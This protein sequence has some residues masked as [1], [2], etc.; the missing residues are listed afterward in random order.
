MNKAA[1]NVSKV[2]LPGIQLGLSLT[3]NVS[4]T[5]V[6]Y[7]VHAVFKWGIL[8]VLAKLGSPEIVGQFGIAYAI[9]IPVLMFTDL[10]LRQIQATDGRNEYLF[11]HFVALR[12]TTSL[13]AILVIS[14]IAISSGFSW[15]IKIVIITV[16]MAKALESLEDIV[17]GFLQKYERMDRMGI[18]IICKGFLELVAMALGVYVTGGLMSGIVG[19]I[20]VRTFIILTYDRRSIHLV[21]DHSHPG[22]PTEFLPSRSNFLVYKPIW[23]KNILPQLAWLSLPVA[24]AATLISLNGTMPRYFIIHYLGEFD[25][26]IFTALS[27]VL[28]GG[29]MVVMALGLSLSPRLAKYY[30]Q[31]RQAE[32]RRLMFKGLLM[33]GLLCFAGVL[34]A[35]LWG[36]GFLTLIYRPEYACQIKVFLWLMIGGTLGF[37]ANFLRSVI[38]AAR[39]LRVQLP[40]YIVTTLVSMA[41]CYYW[42]P[43]Y[44]LIGAAYAVLCSSLLAFILNSLL[45][46]YI[47]WNHYN[48]VTDLTESVAK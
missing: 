43:L 48:K 25:L 19:L 27:Y 1:N 29:S 23:S 21:L 47:L 18:S 8:V 10:N 32:F 39:Y 45:I 26:G 46:S 16:G 12:L 34:G 41:A 11:G 4:W 38:T 17:Y 15:P 3:H 2:S 37:L 14:G 40:I 33:V 13:L 9:G 6:A 36:G 30:A 28:V 31:A 7:I 22:V 44:G 20:L 35:H 42:I 24:V 5:L